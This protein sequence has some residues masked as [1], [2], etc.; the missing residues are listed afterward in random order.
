VKIAYRLLIFVIFATLW[1]PV[2]AEQEPEEVLKAITKI[3]ALVPENART[4]RALGTEREGNGV[5]IGS[6]G[7]V[8]TIGYLIV[9]AETIEVIDSQGNVVNA[10]FLAY[11]DRSG[12]GLL[13]ANKPLEVVPMKLGRSSEVNVGDPLLV[14]GYGGPDAVQGVRVVSRQEFAGYWEYL[15]ED[16]I[17]TLPP[18][19]NFGGAALIGPDGQLLG[20]GSLYTQVMVSG[21]GSVPSNMFVPIDYLKPILTDL[22]TKGRSSEP[23]RPW[24][25]IHAEEAHGRVIVVRISP[26]GPAEK[27]GIRPGDIVLSVNK[28]VVK[29]LSDF[30]RHVWGLG[31]AGIGVPITVLQGV[32]VRD[33]I[34]NSS[35]R[36]QYFRTKRKQ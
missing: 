19:A 16:A 27:A 21:L 35:D 4:A 20:I 1:V 10:I 8:L 13:R 7:L 34:V 33:I 2:S 14:A 32:Q 22:L 30:Y 6:N 29:G 17:F 11:D 5:V 23:P 15:L 31:T 28:N 3:R 36:Y 12:F 18:Y 24:L 25:G 26:E 9:E